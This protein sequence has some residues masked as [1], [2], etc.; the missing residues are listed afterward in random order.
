[1][2]AAAAPLIGRHDFTSYETTGSSRLTTV[3]T[4]FDLTVERRQA[5]FVSTVSHELRTPL[6]SILGALDVVMEEHAQDLAPDSRKFFDIA[7]R[8]AARLSGLVD[9]ILD[10]ER[11]E[12]GLHD[13]R[14]GAVLVS[15]FLGRAVDLN[16]A[17]AM[18]FSVRLTLDQ[19]PPEVYL[20][21]DPDRLMQVV[22]N[23]ISNATKF[24]PQGEAVAVS[25]EATELDVRILV[26]DNGPGVPA[27][28]RNRIF[29]RFAQ[30]ETLDR[31]QRS[32]SGLGLSISK[33]LMDRMSG[34][35]GFESKPGEGTVFYVTLPRANSMGVLPAVAKA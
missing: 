35:I 9:S 19:C 16:S 1:M 6:T 2:Q 25:A 27:D 18:R 14:Y 7:Y 22:T 30:A 28:F 24:S 15:E 5:E 10:L 20:W 34:E 29:Q 11:V 12:K 32:G 33:A 13:F 23:L 3:R 31:R 17:Y 21:A 4:I 8:N 26:K